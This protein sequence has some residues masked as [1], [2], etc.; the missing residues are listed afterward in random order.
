MENGAVID[1]ISLFEASY[2]NIG[3]K[4]AI[5]EKKSIIRLLS[6]QT[7]TNSSMDIIN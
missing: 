1:N 5:D 6:N 3:F 2:Y 4:C 7:Y